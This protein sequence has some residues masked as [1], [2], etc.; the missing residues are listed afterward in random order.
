MRT[1]TRLSGFWVANRG[2][3]WPSVGMRGVSWHVGAIVLTL[4]AG[5]GNWY[6]C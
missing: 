5:R 1:S 6:L 4:L 2:P 3:A